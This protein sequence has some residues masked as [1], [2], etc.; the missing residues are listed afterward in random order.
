M[1][2]IGIA[3]TRNSLLLGV[4][5]TLTVGVIAVTYALTKDRIADQIRQAEAKALYEILPEESHDNDLLKTTVT[6]TPNEDLGN[7][8]PTHGYVAF[9]KQQPTA[10]ILPATAPDGYNGRIL[11]LVGIYADGSLSGV[12]VISHKETPG[13]GDA[14]D[15]KVS[16]WILGFAGKSLTNPDQ[17]RWAVKKDGGDFDQFTGATITP[18]AVVGSIKRTLSYFNKHQ[19]TLFQQGLQQLRTH[20]GE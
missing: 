10:I 7:E 13:L 18:R 6:I 1:N 8:K 14:I 17:D 11:L 9:Q 3:I 5:A 4:F 2:V 15:T 16:D 20:D 12:R 19:D